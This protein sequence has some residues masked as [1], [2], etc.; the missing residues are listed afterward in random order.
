MKKNLLKRIVKVITKHKNHWSDKKLIASSLTGILL[1][2][3]SLFVNYFASDYATDKASSAVQDIFLSN[4]P[5]F[6]VDFIVNDMAIAFLIF[7]LLLIVIEPKRIPFVLK[8]WALFIL[9]R[10][11]FIVMTHLGPFPT[12]S[13]IG[14]H[15][16]LRSFNIG[17]DMFFS[18]HTGLPFLAALV[19]WDEKWI[20]YLFLAASVVFGASVI[21]GHLHYSIDVFAAF[22]I[23]YSI[24]HMSQRL[25]KKDYKF[26]SKKETC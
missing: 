3:A 8:S 4:F 15:D 12:Q 23:T 14:R 26:F 17:G 13:H 19:F 10:S 21:L 20:R 1:F 5:V 7:F 25:F 24:F 11:A 6:N 22:F 16:L 2:S 18:G 9:I